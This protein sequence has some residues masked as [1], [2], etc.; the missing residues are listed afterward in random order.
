MTTMILGFYLLVGFAVVWDMARYEDDEP[1]TATEGIV[2]MFL[3][4]PFLVKVLFFDKGE[5]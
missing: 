2:I 4:L 1:L 3:W 5:K